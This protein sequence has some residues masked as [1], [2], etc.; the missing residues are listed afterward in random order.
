MSRPLRSIY[1]MNDM[2]AY[3]KWITV[4]A[5]GAPPYYTP[6]KTIAKSKPRPK[7]VLKHSSNPRSAPKPRSKHK[8]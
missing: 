4:I 8:R 6:K 7:S 1:P 5:P 2:S 3:R